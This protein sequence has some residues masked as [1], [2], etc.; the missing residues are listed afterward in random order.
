ME[1]LTSPYIDTEQY[2]RISLQSYQMNTDINI[3]LKFNLKKKVEKSCTKDG[4]VVKVY[5]IIEQN[6]GVIQPENFSASAVFDIKYSCKLCLPVEDT[7]ILAKIRTINKVL[8]VAENGPILC[9]VLANNVNMDKFKISNTNGFFNIEKKKELEPDDY[10]QIHIISKTFNYGDNQIK[11]MGY[12][13][14]IASE[15]EVSDFFDTSY[16][17][18][19]LI[20]QNTEKDDGNTDNSSDEQTDFSDDDQ[21]GG[22]VKSN[23]II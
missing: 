17:D 5:K 14:D 8:M 3:N 19:E 23:Y 10:I 15:E 4:Y 22:D 7:L 18:N 12:L 9:I 21:V 11:V 16:T 20:L 2:S 1:K 13:Q 6:D